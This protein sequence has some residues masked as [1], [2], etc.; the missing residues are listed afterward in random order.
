MLISYMSRPL[1][2]NRGLEVARFLFA[3]WRGWA[4]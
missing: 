3:R 1:P 4:R 2:F